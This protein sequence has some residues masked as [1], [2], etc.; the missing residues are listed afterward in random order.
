MVKTMLEPDTVTLFSNAPDVGESTER[1]P[2]QYAGETVT[3]P[4]K[5]PHAREPAG[6]VPASTAT[7]HTSSSLPYSDVPHGSLYI[8]K[9]REKD[10]PHPGAH[11]SPF[12]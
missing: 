12:V 7:K 10:G 8:T 1:L 2:A 11:P 4:M 6:L 9:K 5:S 3:M